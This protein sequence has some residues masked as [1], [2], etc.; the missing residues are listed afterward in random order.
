MSEDHKMTFSSAEM[1]D[2]VKNTVENFLERHLT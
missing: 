1:K 2:K